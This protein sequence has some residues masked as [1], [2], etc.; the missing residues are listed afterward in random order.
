MP[1]MT[2]GERDYKRELNWEHKK[3]PN[4]VLYGGFWSWYGINGGIMIS[5]RLMNWLKLGGFSEG[6]SVS[7]YLGWLGEAIE[8][9]NAE[10]WDKAKVYGNAKVHGYA[11]VCG[12]TF[13]RGNAVVS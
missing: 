2:N 10:V 11:S 9:G 7:W 4:R 5:D 13:V 8:Y 3:K 6:E 1:F 12:V